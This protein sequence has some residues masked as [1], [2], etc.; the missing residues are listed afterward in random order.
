MLA[1][2]ID[3]SISAES[4]SG[5]SQTIEKLSRHYHNL[6]KLTFH[7]GHFKEKSTQHTALVGNLLKEVANYKHKRDEEKAT[8]ET[9]T[10]LL[11]A[12]E[13]EMNMS[14]SGEFVRVMQP[15][16]AKNHAESL[17]F[18]IN[19]LSAFL[20]SK[21]RE[22][23]DKMLIE[24][25]KTIK[26]TINSLLY[27]IKF[28]ENL[29]S[30]L[31]EVHEFFQLNASFTGN[32]K[33]DNTKNRIA[34]LRIA[35]SALLS[36]VETQTK[37][38]LQSF[39]QI[40]STIEYMRAEH[41]G[42]REMEEKE[43]EE[44]GKVRKIAENYLL[45]IR[46]EAIIVPNTRFAI[47]HYQS[48]PSQALFLAKSCVIEALFDI[49]YA[50]KAVK[51]VCSTDQLYSGLLSLYMAK[52]HADISAIR[53]NICPEPFEKYLIRRVTTVN[54]LLPSL[55]QV[56]NG[57]KRLFPAQ[58]AKIACE[59]LGLLGTEEPLSLHEE[60]FIVR[61]IAE[62]EGKIQKESWHLQ[63]NEKW[64]FGGFISLETAFTMIE[65][66]FADDLETAGLVIAAISP[67][68]SLSDLSIS[69]ILFSLQA[70]KLTSEDLF[71]KLDFRR[72]NW[73][74]KEDFIVNIRSFL[75]IFLPFNCL[76]ALFSQLDQSL[77]IS[78]AEFTR[79]F[80][81]NNQ[82]RIRI[83]RISLLN[84]LRNAYKEWQITAK[85]QLYGDFITL[86][87]RDNK[88]AAGEVETLLRRLDPALTEAQISL[89]VQRSS[90]IAGKDVDFETFGKCLQLFPLG[91]W[92]KSFFGEC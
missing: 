73:I 72:E 14:E 89:Y 10:A 41:Q 91:K 32:E 21:D 52:A 58:M 56:I 84:A 2:P 51:T 40:E 47:S 20:A 27:Y 81:A 6:E 77:C 25:L 92:G 5:L 74:S 75:R 87:L 55:P 70:F 34:K 24:A 88:A 38:S 37:A 31:K 82:S 29:K 12:I 3:L 64:E 62:M 11:A 48:A 71:R 23:V 15:L 4:Q 78:H 46:E 76:E 49:K 83:S 86:P 22:K 80:Q 26:N 67:N 44:A 7:L 65:N 36:S 28:L 57:L 79:L 90:G 30:D 59:L 18:C 39:Q 60:V 68:I 1:D 33:A 63:I 9:T 8:V 42:Y 43:A 17:R 61:A 50:D 85:T 35:T 45:R 19:R 16:Q 69:Y 54:E 66:W 13:K 53:S